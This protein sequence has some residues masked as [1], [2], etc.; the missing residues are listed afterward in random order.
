MQLD[1]ITHRLEFKINYTHLVH[2]FIQ[3]RIVAMIIHISNQSSVLSVQK[4]Q[5]AND[6]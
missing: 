5:M 2:F 6:E 4:K 1:R 3:R